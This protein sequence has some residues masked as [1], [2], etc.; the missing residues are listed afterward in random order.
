MSE[1]Y[2]TYAGGKQFNIGLGDYT[3]AKNLDIY[4][5]MK[6]AKLPLD[7]FV[8]IEPRDDETIY[9]DKKVVRGALTKEGELKVDFKIGKADNPK[10]NALLLVNGP[11]EKNTHFTNYKAFRKFL[12]DL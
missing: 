1:A 3:V 12:V 5:T 11:A 4:E 10:V 7:L 2:F 9:V 6:G 8:E